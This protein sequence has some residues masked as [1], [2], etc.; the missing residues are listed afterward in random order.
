[1]YYGLIQQGERALLVDEETK[2]ARTSCSSNYSW[3][4]LSPASQ[5]KRHSN[6]V[7][8]RKMYAE[9]ASKLMDVTG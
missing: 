6:L 4:K 5:A 9:R 8:E 7:K 1:M 3:T 2:K